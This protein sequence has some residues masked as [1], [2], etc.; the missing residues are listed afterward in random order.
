MAFAM[1]FAV[2]SQ[3]K[4]QQELEQRRQELRREIQA[5]NKVLKAEKNEEK[6]VLSLVEDL[7]YKISVQQNLIKVTN[8]QAN[9]LTREINDNQKNITSLRKQLKKL[10][11][12]Y[13]SMIVKSYKGKNEQSRVMFLLSSSNFQQAFK[14]LEYIKQYANFQKQQAEEIKIKAEKLQALNQQLL[15]QKKDKQKLI[16]ENRIAKRELEK[17]RKTQET[18]MASIKKNLSKYS[19]QVTKKQKEVSRIDREIN[20]IIKSAIAASNKKA[21]KSTSSKTFALTPA[22]KAL[23]LNFASNKGKLPWP[24]SEG[25]VTLGYGKHKHPVVKSTTIVNNGLRIATSKNAKAKAIFKGEV[26]S[27]V[28]IKGAKPMVMVRHGN[29]ITIYRNLSKVYVKQGDKINTGNELG[30]V[31]TDS[32][33]KTTLMFSIFKDSSPINPSYWLLKR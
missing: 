8:Q 3:S 13:A 12:G 2:Q 7:D 25:A 5:I 33:G 21:G 11:E 19:R 22:S 30:E 28:K 31:A 29:Y 16:D 23:A 27:I 14:R 18:L 26:S 32:E 9:L 24:V 20:N 6:S 15:T 4:K 1:S 10:K 17:E